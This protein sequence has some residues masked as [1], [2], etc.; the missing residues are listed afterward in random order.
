MGDGG[1]PW[2]ALRPVLIIGLGYLAAWTALDLAAEHFEA[3]PGVSVWYPPAALDIVLLL[4]FG[5]RYAPFVLA[6]TFI[7]T[8]VINP[9]GLSW[10]LIGLY[11]IVT[12]AGPLVAVAVL[13][14]RLR[15]DPRLL[16]QRDVGWFVAIAC[17]V[18]PVLMAAAQVATLTAA[19]AVPGDEALISIAGLA[20]GTATG[21]AML[22][23]VLLV[24]ARRWRSR[25]Q[26]HPQPPP[27]PPDLVVSRWERAA[28]L[29]AVVGTGWAAYGPHSAGG[30]LDYTYLVYVPLIWVAVRAGFRFA[31]LA[32]LLTAVTAAVANGGRIPE[33][34]GIALQFGLVTLTLTGLLLGALVTQRHAD[35]EAH[36]HAALHDPLTGLANRALFS[37][38]LAHAIARSD[39]HPRTHYAVLFLDLD[40]FKGV[41]DSLGH[42][43]GDTVLVQVAERLRRVTRAQDSLARFGGDEFTIL[44]EDLSGLPALTPLADRVLATLALPHRVEGEE[45]IVPASIGVVLAVGDSHT[46]DDLLRS[47]D[48]ALHQAKRSGRGRQVLFDPEMQAQ[49]VAGLR[50]EAQLRAALADGHLTVV[51][52]PVLAVPGGQLVAA[53]ALA[54]WPSTGS[55][56]VPPEKFVALAEDAGLI[57]DLGR[58]VL[59]RAC[60]TAA[61]WPAG[62]DGQAVR[63]AVNVSPLELNSASYP[64]TVRDALA[65]AELPADRLVLEVTEHKW[66]ANDP[67][68]E[69]VLAELAELG[70]HLV[71]DDFGA[72][73]SSLSRLRR[74]PVHGL[75]IDRSFVAG[76]PH[77]QDAVAIVTAILALARQ[78][79]LDVTAEGVETVEQYDFLAANGCPHAQGFLLGVPA[80]TLQ[81]TPLVPTLDQG[82]DPPEAVIPPAFK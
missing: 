39:R 64:A 29:V 52:Q 17:A 65:A 34:G 76:L 70:V 58:Y 36:R 8:T 56:E 7:H 44:V 4:L 43:A 32:V 9:V 12:S 62:A 54:R 61:R 27:D 38:R 69:A 14:H 48:T 16:S 18:G 68:A 49:A 23:P 77:D 33:D 42:A 66:P 2:R 47:A 19:G 53:E 31:T 80:P 51:F 73:H 78:L 46:P 59:T 37:D 10:P 71:I 3:A 81:I 24:G 22:A 6:S 63:V 13:V 55:A 30:T 72:G 26:E 50:Q 20:A 74:L 57:G 5:L 45:V 15:I 1:L 75:K 40:R 82:H 25:W 79:N 35:A 41:N 28:Q 60:T 67:G 11:D 21:V